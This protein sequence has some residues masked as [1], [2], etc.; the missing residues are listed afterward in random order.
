MGLSTICLNQDRSYAVGDFSPT[1]AL[2]PAGEGIAFNRVSPIRI[3]RIKGFSG[4]AIIRCTGGCWCGQF[5][6]SPLEGSEQAC[7]RAVRS[8]LAVRQ[9][10]HGP[11]MN[12]LNGLTA[13]TKRP[14]AGGGDSYQPR[15]SYQDSQ[16]QR[17]F[18]TCHHPLYGRMLVRA[19]Q[20]QPVGRLRA[21]PS[22]GRPFVVGGS[23]GSPWSHHER[24]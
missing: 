22:K 14:F 7:P 15:K 20:P 10:H 17:I 2:P 11:T 5:N 9:A 23:T 1:L 8:W 4:F 12:G 21:G 16:D 3:H 18:W 13:K 24:T 19:I 6:P